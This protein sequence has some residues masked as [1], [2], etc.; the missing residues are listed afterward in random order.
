MIHAT[1]VQT[2]CLASSSTLVQVRLFLC[3]PKR[4]IYS[5]RICFLLCSHCF[6]V[7]IGGP[8]LACAFAKA[9]VMMGELSVRIVVPMDMKNLREDQYRVL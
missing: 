7:M 1:P 4:F 9:A 3:L 8:W 2:Y 6:L 5:S